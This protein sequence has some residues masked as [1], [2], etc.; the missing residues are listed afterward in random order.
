MTVPRHE[1]PG[2]IVLAIGVFTSSLCVVGLILLWL[3]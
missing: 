1:L 3:G 2:Q